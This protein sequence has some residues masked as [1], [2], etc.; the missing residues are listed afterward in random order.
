VRDVE[1]LFEELAGHFLG[2]PGVER[3]KMFNGDGLKVNGKFFAFVAGD[4]RLV[5]K[6]PE[7]LAVALKE[8]GSAEPMS[9]GRG[10]M[11][12]WVGV[13]PLDAPEPDGWLPLV[14]DAH[15]YVE[16]LTRRTA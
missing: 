8:A 6:V 11:R 14:E 3:G 7:A 2:R 1:E 15:R 9:T 16:E 12:E 13:R 10:T 4:E 5:V